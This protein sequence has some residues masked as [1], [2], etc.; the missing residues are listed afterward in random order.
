M[1][2]DEQDAREICLM[3]EAAFSEGQFVSIQ[4]LKRIEQ[5]FRIVPQHMKYLLESPA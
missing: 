3:A 2:F 1:T 5:E 4:L